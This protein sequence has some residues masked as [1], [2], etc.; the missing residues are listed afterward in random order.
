LPC[1]IRLRQYRRLPSRIQTLSQVGACKQHA[2]CAHGRT[3]Y[4][5]SIVFSP[6]ACL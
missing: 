5:T 4:P 1:V 3:K 6:T 2:G